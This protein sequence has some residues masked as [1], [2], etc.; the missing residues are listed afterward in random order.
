MKLVIGRLKLGSVKSRVCL[1]LLLMNLHSHH[2]IHGWLVSQSITLLGKDGATHISGHGLA[3]G[4]G[5]RR[6]G[7]NDFICPQDS[8][9]SFSYHL[10]KINIRP[11]LES[12]INTAS[13]VC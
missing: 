1:F 8:P 5:D 10:D 6:N 12:G 2:L 13:S 11:R 9:R 7:L 4:W 3:V